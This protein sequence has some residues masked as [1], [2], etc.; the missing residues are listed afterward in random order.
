VQVVG[1][2]HGH[3]HTSPTS[4]ARAHCYLVT[5]QSDTHILILWARE[6][7]KIF[8]SCQE[9]FLFCIIQPSLLHITAKE[10]AGIENHHGGKQSSPKPK[11]INFLFPF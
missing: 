5:I 9:M 11:E 3:I 7:E 1:S 4:Y 10:L 6:R 2:V 8:K